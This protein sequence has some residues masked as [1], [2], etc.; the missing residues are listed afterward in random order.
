[1]TDINVEELKSYVERI[2]RLNCEIESLKNDVHEIFVEMK[3]KYDIKA[4]QKVIA[5]R[6]KNKAEVQEVDFMI[7]KYEEVL[8]G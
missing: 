2:E 7:S 6:K 1:M 8:G 3:D 5:R 4:I